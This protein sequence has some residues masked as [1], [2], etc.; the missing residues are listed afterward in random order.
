MPP[1]TGEA[2]ALELEARVFGRYLVGR[3]PPGELVDR[4]RA[5]STTLF[6]TL[7]GGPDAAIIAF[8]RRHPWSVP[9]LDA[10]AAIV[11]PA[12]LLRSKILVMSAILEASPAFADEF[13]PRNVPLAG[14]ALRVVGLGMWAVARAIVGAALHAAVSR[15]RA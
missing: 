15:G 2:A 10:G 8:A 4:Y 7:V 5:A 9:F 6:G 14:L 13:L 1:E 12:G 11:R 3:V